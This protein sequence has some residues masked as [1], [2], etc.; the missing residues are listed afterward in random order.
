[1]EP[2]KVSSKPDKCPKCGGK[3]LSILYGDPMDE[4]IEAYKRGEIIL[5]GCCIMLDE[6]GNSLMPD[7]QCKE[8]EAQF[9]AE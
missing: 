2:I 4:A 6:S 9:I 3:V 1:M 8:C 7:W 5:G